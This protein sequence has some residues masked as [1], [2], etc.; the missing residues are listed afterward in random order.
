MRRS[1]LWLAAGLLAA[2]CSSPPK[3][4]RPVDP[5]LQR[6]AS[7]A[8]VSFRHGAYGQAEQLYR[9]ALDRARAA[10]DA[11]EIGNN[12]YNLAACLVALGR[13]EAARPLL[14]EARAELERARQNTAEVILLEAGAA[15]NLGQGEEAAALVEES[16]ARLDRDRNGAL[17]IQ[18]ALLE[19]QL[20][21]DGN[22]APRAFRVLASI[23]K[24]LERKGDAL[25]NGRAAGLQARITWMTGQPAVA[26]SWLDREA[27]GYRKA[28]R[29]PHEIAAVLRRAGEAWGQAGQPAESADRYYRAARSL[30]GQ[31]DTVAALKCIEPALAAAEKAGRPDL[32]ARI[33]DLFLE[34]R[35]KTGA[36]EPEETK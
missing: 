29:P 28:G 5:D 19:A 24:D 15:R 14:R 31:G 36:I 32:A 3:P 13:D 10:D 21:A 18:A 7:S 20:A 35:R 25:L 33:A 4:A 6:Y 16:R 30:F 26:A 1:V 23:E 34:I 22:D 27:A 11:R 17:W 9:R 2:G 12:A 8:Q